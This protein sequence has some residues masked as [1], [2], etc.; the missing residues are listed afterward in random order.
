[1]D[2]RRNAVKN[3]VLNR[4]GK[5]KHSFRSLCQSHIP[6]KRHQIEKSRFSLGAQSRQRSDAITCDPKLD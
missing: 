5:T 3:D 2:F 4:L 1:M 6:Q